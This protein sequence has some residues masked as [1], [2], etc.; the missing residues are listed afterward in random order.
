MI[1]LLFEQLYEITSLGIIHNDINT[2]N[3]IIDN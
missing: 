1:I 2:Y 3:I